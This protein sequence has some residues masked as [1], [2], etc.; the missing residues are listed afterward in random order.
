MLK[1]KPPRATAATPKWPG[2]DGDGWSTRGS[3]R[4]NSASSR[5]SWMGNL[6]ISQSTRT[7]R[8]KLRFQ[9]HLT[10]STWR[11]TLA[12]RQM[13]LSKRS[14]QS[15]ICAPG[16]GM[17]RPNSGQTPNSGQNF[18]RRLLRRMALGNKSLSPICAPD[19][20][21]IATYLFSSFTGS[22]TGP[23]FWP[24]TPTQRG[25]AQKSEYKQFT[26]K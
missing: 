6:L 23:V 11:T 3:H 10:T 20:V 13:P 26:A 15:G 21:D 16:L 8:P 25:D 12:Y 1:V 7:C 19:L 24:L 2:R 4:T 22:P 14:S 18:D 5:L 17:R 9:R